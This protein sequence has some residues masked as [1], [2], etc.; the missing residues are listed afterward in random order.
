MSE[1]DAL[2]AEIDDIDAQLTALFLRRMDVTERV[3]AYKQA[4]GLPVLDPDRE[5]EVLAKKAALTGDQARKADVTALYESIMAISRRQQRHLVREGE[6][7]GDYARIRDALAHVRAP[8]AAPRVLYQGEPG[9]YSDEAAARFFGEEVPRTHVATWEAVFT[10]L[11]EGRADYGVVP[12]ENSSTGSINQVYDLLSKYGHFIVGEQTV[13]VEHCLAAPRGASL[14][15][16]REVC[17]HEQGLLQCA[18]YLKAH[19]DWVQRPR[20]NT[21]ESALF[22]SR[23]GDPAR[24][25]ICSRRAARLYGLEVLA[26]PINSNRENYTRFVVVSPQ[27][28]LREGRDKLS[29][30]CV[31]PHHSGSL[32][33][34]MTIFAVNGLNLLKLESRPIPG[35]SWEYQFFLDFTG[36]VAAPGMDGALRELCQTA[37][38]F[39]LLGNYRSSGG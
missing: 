20:L 35:R 3:G 2:R 11:E 27:P 25:A 39:R 34:L 10:A 29:A 9:A 24:A 22:V 18:G 1:L 13:K 6:P 36:D 38:G 5:R 14:E 32:H 19:P 31:L 12:I 23:Q 28:E 8:L 26:G 16:I 37:E 4:H 7:G 30:L 17:S 33:A 15:G 21:A